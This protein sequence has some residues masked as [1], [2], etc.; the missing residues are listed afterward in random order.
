VNR[1]RWAISVLAVLL[2][3]VLF[4]PWASADRT[5]A[6]ADRT[7][8]REAEVNTFTGADPHDP[9]VEAAIRYAE[10]LVWADTTLWNDTVAWN[11]A[12]STPAPSYRAPRSSGGSAPA[13]GPCAA[14]A[15]AGF[16][17]WIIQRE[18]GGDPNAVNSSSGALGC[19]QILPSHFAA[20]GGCAGQT[21]A[22]CWATLWAGGAGASNWGG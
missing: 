4:V 1:T 20:G 16:P 6:T 10:G 13:S 2:G 5:R 19:A 12:V 7:R 22:Q 17:G 8:V 14:S 3:A 18:S 21:Y 15:P 9:G 11:A